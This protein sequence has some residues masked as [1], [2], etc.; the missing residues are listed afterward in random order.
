LALSGAAAVSVWVLMCGVYD[1][2]ISDSFVYAL[3]IIVRALLAALLL[4]L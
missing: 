1:H 4:Q 3:H 2:N